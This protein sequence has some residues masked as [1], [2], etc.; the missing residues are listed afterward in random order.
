MNGKNEHLF[1][2]PLTVLCTMILTSTVG[3]VDFEITN[4]WITEEILRQ[5][6]D[7]NGENLDS[8]QRRQLYSRVCSLTKRLDATGIIDRAE[9]RSPSKQVYC[10]IVAI[11]KPSIS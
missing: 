8:V 1:G 4:R 6:T 9:R 11:H 2:T 3:K 7:N 5:Y 10:E